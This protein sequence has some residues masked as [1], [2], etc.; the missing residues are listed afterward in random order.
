M[1]VAELNRVMLR[2][3]LV[4]AVLMFGFGFALVPIYE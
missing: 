3:L 4:V 2:K 1:S